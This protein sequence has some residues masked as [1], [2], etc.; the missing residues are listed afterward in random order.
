MA[1]RIP[2]GETNDPSEWGFFTTFLG[3]MPH[4]ATTLSLNRPLIFRLMRDIRKSR[5]FDE[6]P[7]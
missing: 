7:G 3:V 1:K 6:I 4:F 2:P 5:C